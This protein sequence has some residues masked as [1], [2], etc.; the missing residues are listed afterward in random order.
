MTATKKKSIG[1]SFSASPNYIQEQNEGPFVVYNNT[2]I[3]KVEE[4]HKQ[5]LKEKDEMIA[6]LKGHK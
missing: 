4:L 2:C 6:I 1:S 5:L 3:E